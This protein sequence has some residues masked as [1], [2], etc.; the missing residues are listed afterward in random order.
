MSK[1]SKNQDYP[2][3]NVTFDR[4]V[5]NRRFFDKIFDIY[6]F[7]MIFFVEFF[8]APMEFKENPYS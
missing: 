5:E 3:H 2:G 4:N 6:L 7:F 1:V 8:L